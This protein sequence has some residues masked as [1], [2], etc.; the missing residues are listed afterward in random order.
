[1]K[2][3]DFKYVFIMRLVISIH[4]IVR[5]KSFSRRKCTRKTVHI[6]E[7]FIYSNAS[8]NLS[9]RIINDGCEFGNWQ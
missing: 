8:S 4:H 2:H 6:S 3:A 7:A 1:M 5:V 9:D